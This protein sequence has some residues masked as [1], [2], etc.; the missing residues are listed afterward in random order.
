MVT[1]ASSSENFLFV[2]VLIQAVFSYIKHME[3]VSIHKIYWKDF[4]QWFWYVSLQQI[5]FQL[6]SR[7]GVVWK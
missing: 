2:F 7:I 6:S 4:A 5:T 3:W 1:C